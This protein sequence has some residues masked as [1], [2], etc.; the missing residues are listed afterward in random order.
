MVSPAMKKEVKALMGAIRKHDNE[1]ARKLLAGNPALVNAC[2]SA[3]PKKDD[4][5]SP[6]QI[7]FKC[8]NFEIAALLIDQGA[9]INF[10]EESAVNEWRTPVLHDALRAAAFTARDGKIVSGNKF[11]QAIGLV[12][13][14]LSMGANPHATDSYGNSPLLRVLMDAR[15]RLVAEPGFPNQVTN[16]GLNRDLREILQVLIRA[17]ADVNASSAQRESAAAYATEPA[18]AALL[19]GER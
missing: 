6:L 1:T 7:A 11:E 2:A 10:I 9:N 16:G 12:Q 4:G 15:Q 17:G 8:G 19:Q 18:L 13:K 14:L 3:P 5:Q